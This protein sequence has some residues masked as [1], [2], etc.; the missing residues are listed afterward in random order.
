MN[1]S[2]GYKSTI[3]LLVL[4]VSILGF[5]IINKKV[6]IDR[7]N[8]VVKVNKLKIENKGTKKEKEIIKSGSDKTG[9]EVEKETVSSFSVIKYEIN[10]K[11]KHERN[12]KRDAV[13]NVKLNDEDKKY[14]VLNEVNKENITSKKVPDGL[15]IIVKDVETN[16]DYKLEIEV[17]INNAP[18]GYK[19]SPIVEVKEKTS[20]GTEVRPNTIEVKT[21]SLEGIVKNNKNEP[22]SNV[23][24]E[25]CLMDKNVCINRK[26]TYT[27]A[28]GKYVFSGLGEGEY[29]VIIPDGYILDNDTTL[30]SSGN[31]ELNI[32]YDQKGRFSASIKKYLEK[33]KVGEKE[34]EFDK[35]QTVA[36]STINKDKIE[37]NYLFEIKNVSD[38]DGY[39]K[40]IRESLPDG[41]IISNDELNKDWKKDGQYYINSSLSNE[42]LKVG[43]TKYIRIKIESEDKVSAAEYKNKVEILGESY[44]TVKYV[45]NNEVYKEYEVADGEKI[46]DYKIEREGYTFKGWYTNKSY[47]TKFNFNNLITKDTI[48]YGNLKSNQI[49]KRTVTYM[50]DD[51]TIFDIKE[52]DDGECAEDIP[53]PEKEGYTFNYWKKDGVKYFNDVSC[54]PVTEDIVLYSDFEIN[55]YDIKYYIPGELSSNN[56]HYIFSDSFHLYD[57][58]TSRVDYKTYINDPGS[59]DIKYFNFKGWYKEEELTNK[60][61]Y[62]YEVKKDTNFYGKYEIKKYNVEFYNSRT[63]DEPFLE[64]TFEATS[65]VGE[66]ESTPPENYSI[67]EWQFEDGSKVTF[68]DIAYE[69]FR[70]FDENEVIK[71]YRVLEGIKYK[72]RY[73]DYNNELI[74]ENAEE[75]LTLDA[76]PEKMDDYAAIVG[77]EGHRSGFRFTSFYYKDEP[78]SEYEYD[79]FSDLCESKNNCVIDLVAGYEATPPESIYMVFFDRMGGASVE[80]PK[81]ELFD[82]SKIPEFTGVGGPWISYNLN[83]KYAPIGWYKVLTENGTPISGPDGYETEDEPFS[84]DTEIINETTYVSAKYTPNKY[85]IR[86][87]KTSNEMQGTMEDQVVEYSSDNYSFNPYSTPKEKINIYIH[88]NEYIYPGKEFVGWKSD[89]TGDS[90]ISTSVYSPFNAILFEDDDHKISEGVYL[91]NLYPTFEDKSYW[92]S[93]NKNTGT[94]SMS[95]DSF[96]TSDAATRTLK[97]NAFTKTGYKFKGWS[98]EPGDNKEIVY[99]NKESLVNVMNKMDQLNIDYQT[100]YA[101]FEPINYTVSF[102]KEDDL[103]IGEMQDQAFTYDTPQNLRKNTYTKVGYEFKGWKYGDI[104]YT[105]EQEVTN[106]TTEDNAVITLKTNFEIKKYKVIFMHQDS[107]YE[108]QNNVEYGSHIT[109][110]STNPTIENGNFSGWKLNGEDTIFDFENRVANDDISEVIDGENVIIFVSSARFIDPPVITTEP[111]EWTNDKVKITLSNSNNYDMKL[112]VGEASYV[113]YTEP[114]YT[115]VNTE[116]RGKNYDGNYESPEAIKEITN[117]DKINP[118]VSS[119]ENFPSSNSSVITSS[120]VDEDSGINSARIV[121]TVGSEDVTYCETSTTKSLINDR[122]TGPSNY[123]YECEVSGLTESTTYIG[124]IITTDVAGNESEREIEFSTSDPEEI[125]ARII[126][127]DGVDIENPEDYIDYPSLRTALEGC[128]TVSSTNK[129]TIQM[130]KST[131]ESN[132]VNSDL[133]IVLDLNG[134]TINGVDTVTITNNGKLQIVDHNNTYEEETLESYEPIGKIINVHSTLT[135]DENNNDVEIN[136][137][138]AILNNANAI[139]KIGENEVDDDDEGSIVSEVE[140]H[141]EGSAKGVDVSNSNSTF[142]FYDGIIIGNNASIYGT[143]NGKPLLYD[144]NNTSENGPQEATLKQLAD[145]IARVKRTGVYFT[146][147]DSARDTTNNGAYVSREVEPT[148]NLIDLIQ[149][150][151]NYAATFEKISNKT[152]Y[153]IDQT[154]NGYDIELSDLKIN[155]NNSIKFQKEQVTMHMPVIFEEETTE[156][157]VQLKILPQRRQYNNNLY[158][159]TANEKISINIANERLY[160]YNGYSFNLPESFYDGNIKDIT[161]IKN[162]N[163]YEAYVNGEK[164]EVYSTETYV[165]SGSPS[166]PLI[167]YYN[168]SY[169]Y[170]DFY[171]LKVY[172]KA[173]T[174]EEVITP[175]TDGLMLHYNTLATNPTRVETEEPVL[176]NGYKESPVSYIK[177]DLTGYDQDQKLLVEASK[178]GRGYA[179]AVVREASETYNE[180]YIFNGSINNEEGLF[181]SLGSGDAAKTTYETIIEHGKIYYLYFK[182]STNTNYT[183]D[184]YFAIHSVKLVG[185]SVED[186]DINILDYEV[187]NESNTYGFVYDN[188][189]NVLVNNNQKVRSSVA[190]ATYKIPVTPLSESK[191]LTVNATISSESSDKALLAVNTS[192]TFNTSGYFL[193][194]GGNIPATDYT[195]TLS[196]NTEYYLHIR[197]SK[198]YYTDSYQ[199]SFIINSIKVGDQELLP[200]VLYNE[201]MTNLTYFDQVPKLNT[202]FET[203]DERYKDRDTIELVRDYMMDSTFDVEETRDVVLDLKGHTLTSSNSTDYM[204]NNKGK[205]TITDSSYKKSL[206]SIIESNN[207]I[208]EQFNETYQQ[209]MEEYGEEIDAINEV[210]RSMYENTLSSLFIEDASY[211]YSDY[212]NDYNLRYHY[213]AQESGKTAD[214]WSDSTGHYYYENNERKDLKATLRGDPTWGGDGGLVLDGDGDYIETPKYASSPDSVQSV[215]FKASRLG[216]KQAL[217]TYRERDY[218]YVVYIMPTNKLNLTITIDAVDYS[219]ETAFS[220]SKDTIYSVEVHRESNKYLLYVN[221]HLIDTFEKASSTSTSQVWPNVQ[222]TY[223]GVYSINDNNKSLYFN[224]TIYNIRAFSYYGSVM[225]EEMRNNF[226]KVDAS[227]YNFLPYNAIEP[228][229]GE[230]DSNSSNQ[231]TDLLFDGN[232]N[233][234]YVANENELVVTLSRNSENT[235]RSFKLYGTDETDKYPSSVSLEGSK[236]GTNYVTMINEENVSSKGYGEFNKFTVENLDSYK[237]YRWTFTSSNGISIGEISPESYD[238]KRMIRSASGMEIENIPSNYAIVG[239]TTQPSLSSD[240][241]SFSN[242]L[243]YVEKVNVGDNPI[244]IDGVITTDCN[245]SYETSTYG[246]LRVGFSSTNNNNMNDFVSYKDYPIRGKMTGSHYNVKITE[247]GEYYVKFMLNKNSSSTRVTGNFYGLKIDDT[248]KLNVVSELDS[249]IHGKIMSS[250]YDGIQNSPDSELIIDDAIINI[251]KSGKMAINN[252]GKLSIKNNSIINVLSGTSYGIT[253]N[254]YGEIYDSNG[255][256]NLQVTSDVGINNKSL[257]NTTLSDLKIN[258]SDTSDIGIKQSVKN[259]LTLNNIKTTGLGTSVENLNDSKL[260]LTNIDFSSDIGVSSSGDTVLNSGSIEATISGISITNGTFTMNGGSIIG[261]KNGI[262]ENT[263]GDIVINDG[264]II[265]YVN[266]IFIKSL[267]NQKIDMLGGKIISHDVGIYMYNDIYNYYY[268]SS[269]SISDATIESTNTAIF[270]GNNN[271]IRRISNSNIISNYGYGIYYTPI[272]SKSITPEPGYYYRAKKDLVIENSNIKTAKTSIRLD[273][274]D[275]ISVLGT[276]KI[277]SDESAIEST[278]GLITL[279]SKDGNV[280]NNYPYI[281]S[282]A[283]TF[284]NIGDFNFYDGKIIG[285]IDQ[286]IT[287]VKESEENY[288]ILVN[289]LSNTRE[290]VTLWLPTLNADESNAVAKIGNTKYASLTSAIADLGEESKTIEIIKNYKTIIPVAIGEGKT[291]V[292]DLGN[293][294]IK[295]YSSDDFITNNGNIKIQSD[296]DGLLYSD[297]AKIFENNGTLTTKDL[298][299][300]INNYINNAINNNGNITIDKGC[301][302]VS[303]KD[304]GT[305]I[306]T[307]ADSTITIDTAYVCANTGTIIN[308]NDNSEVTM[309]DGMYIG[310]HGMN[311]AENAKLTINGSDIYGNNPINNNGEVIFNS[312]SVTYRTVIPSKDEGTKTGIINNS[313]FTMNNGTFD[314][315]YFSN[316][317]TTSEFIMNNGQMNNG[318]IYNSNSIIITG[319]QLYNNRIR[320]KDGAILTLGVKG[321]GETSITSPSLIY[322]AYSNDDGLPIDKSTNSTFNFYDGILK[323]RGVGNIVPDEI[324]DGYN[325][326]VSSD[327]T[328]TYKKYLEKLAVAQIGDDKYYSLADAIA[329]DHCASEHCDIEII[330]NIFLPQS[331]DTFV[332]T[333]NQDITINLNQYYIVADNPLLFNNAGTLKIDATNH[334]ANN[335]TIIKC[336]KLMNNTGTAQIEFKNHF[337]YLTIRTYNFVSNTGTLTLKNMYLNYQDDPFID[338]EYYPYV[339]NTGTGVAN[340]EDYIY[341]VRI[342]NS[343]NSKV[344]VESDKE[345]ATG[346]H[347]SISLK[348]NSSAEINGGNNVLQYEGDATTNTLVKEGN[349]K[350]TTSG[351]LNINP[352]ENQNPTVEL[353]LLADATTNVYGGTISSYNNSGELNIYKATITGSQRNTETG[354][355]T[356]G[357]KDGIYEDDEIISTMTDNSPTASE[358]QVYNLGII[359]WYDGVFKSNILPF[360]KLPSDI[361]SGYSIITSSDDTY[362]F[363]TKLSNGPVAKIGTTEFSSLQAAVDSESCQSGHCEIDIIKGFGILK[364]GQPVN[365]SSGR[366]IKLNLNGHPLMSSEKSIISNAGTLEIYDSD[367]AIIRTASSTSINN[368]G[369]LTINMSGIIKIV[370]PLAE[371]DVYINNSGVLNITKLN[372]DAPEYDKNVRYIGI[373]NTGTLTTEKDFV[374]GTINSYSSSGASESSLDNNRVI[375]SSSNSTT[376]I[377]GSTIV[378]QVEMLDNSSLIINGGYIDNTSIATTASATLN[379]GHV[380]RFVS[381]GTSTINQAEGKETE[382]QFAKNEAGGV[383]TINDGTIENIIKLDSGDV[384]STRIVALGNSGTLYLNGGN[385]LSHR[386]ASYTYYTDNCGVSN[387]GTMYISGGYIYSEANRIVYNTGSLNIT[388]G[389]FEINSDYTESAVVDNYADLVIDGATIDTG[390]YAVLMNKKDLVACNTTIKG[391]ASISG[392]ISAIKTKIN[393]VNLTIG[394]SSDPIS[395]TAPTIKGKTSSGIDNDRKATFNFYD[396]RIIGPSPYS[397]IGDVSPLEGYFVKKDP[398]TDD[399]EGYE[400]ATLTDTAPIAKAILV[401]GVNYPTIEEA[402]GATIEG[403]NELELYI[404]ITLEGTYNLKDN[405]TINI[406][407]NGNTITRGDYQF[408]ANDIS[409]VKVYY[410][411]EESNSLL[412]AIRELLNINPVKIKKNIVVYNDDAGHKINS[413]E[414]YTLLY[415]NGGNYEEIDIK[416]ESIP[417]RYSV[418]RTRSDDKMASYNGSVTI[419]DIPEG[420][421]KLLGDAGTVSTFGIDEEG[422]LTGNIRTT[423]LNDTYTSNNVLAS[424]QA[425]VIVNIQTGQ[426]VIKYGLIICLIGSILVLL[427]IIRKKKF[428]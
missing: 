85:I 380:N 60:V 240:Y 302:L 61:T 353:K 175:T 333:E 69:T 367:E 253:N 184:D 404:P 426:K 40:T 387:S 194:E 122:Q 242:G 211:S 123:N 28:D 34:Y 29:K 281:K 232:I 316:E 273:T 214:S 139:L 383:M 317:E 147:L 36:V 400:I 54:T 278:K 48:L 187:V 92:V 385:V 84:F 45:L 33:V 98:L 427:M 192:S 396:G 289:E 401:N 100:I 283:L 314:S 174:S 355:I 37:A 93:Y 76:F 115:T 57:Q 417:G 13:I 356:Y 218:G 399:L 59:V 46:D 217:L 200:V 413:G 373:K 261:Y 137:G 235:I 26:Q 31:N 260:N 119:F 405:S 296:G 87:N 132:T 263:S 307:N 336:Y 391:N 241:L 8:G 424:S 279:G 150:N 368:T 72:V 270:V 382:I 144:V 375:S 354:T 124:R 73:L 44:H 148:D 216:L 108:V 254:T 1:K 223:Y 4:L 291:G 111:T 19:F 288:D 114:V 104:T 191:T 117:I 227:R 177:I 258:M 145:A 386:D 244:V 326:K 328:F 109:P 275:K 169:T 130:V 392:N 360:S 157:T 384:I 421:Y 49:P 189:R 43:E 343:D 70:T 230:F 272:T 133:D 358:S 345:Y 32:V 195:K 79:L 22:A 23:L 425:D 364:T 295:N 165:G 206:A 411:G 149:P 110:P 204:I 228:T 357:I 196:P 193:N 27:D 322:R 39:I 389:N 38:S 105:D 163:E 135:K 324:E 156:E 337:D 128:Y 365:I 35:K 56:D 294:Y 370:K 414:E 172:N 292:I 62:P 231:N 199:D 220:I 298:S 138:T 136:D 75:T 63:D 50:E 409:T 276:S 408:V 120:L 340:I 224:G 160:A 266:G 51:T 246:T 30:V 274:G 402:F 248:P 86:Y 209:K 171:E 103:V 301:S 348:D 180:N 262:E 252:Y 403:Y 282:E 197:Y 11:L 419:L 208:Q 300:Q 24:V 331:A 202:E 81:G 338:P 181:I 377:N 158:I 398:G 78:L 304:N 77:A 239:G 215:I 18:N 303:S 265:S 14:V 151:K 162:N 80:T 410:D 318:S 20:E 329:S 101:Q 5:L 47:S 415:N 225:P 247:P 170:M 186:P 21:T 7:Y 113:D 256:I 176:R 89:V 178:V 88:N 418:S 309:N 352:G 251:N 308:I 99:S 285:P 293:K 327:E 16:I 325:L 94:G 107:E 268:N 90:Y 205:L 390:N 140:P 190:Y 371:D 416:S 67:K 372:L 255:Y 271:D 378:S 321:D 71:I 154:G 91:L 332:I 406:I 121:V 167:G 397:I 83:G 183:P 201:E 226:Y 116:V 95:G 159:G 234:K 335:T 233:N 238:V 339:D 374:V 173:L 259:D 315:I 10:Y 249:S 102:E 236:D 313:T 269:L 323:G 342:I 277:V 41:F 96:T 2:K 428:Q 297:F 361:E 146:N 52:V 393:T 388:G 112:K 203:S 311:V 155:E 212:P 250:A 68:G 344:N 312:G 257:I 363:I 143:V 12:I 152:E 379:Y 182:Y 362:K 118:S 161:V 106:L 287:N 305:L 381:G 395:T 9:T 319:G 166:I 394:D 334:T 306:N 168:S 64:T 65:V 420:E 310:G 129:C 125:I 74:D 299:M 15:E 3:I 376:T 142:Y 237:Y 422:N 219:I 134:K 198:N 423:Y 207:Q 243:Y 188:K 330:N 127:Y 320:N 25:A 350:I 210:N 245:E 349:V 153:L 141:I 17:Q 53:G 229:F 412:A 164:L 179:Y 369:T 58:F 6:N 66:P 346:A 366:D 359:N 341:N 42:I 82:Q 286:T 221:N 185:K 55:K 264:N 284:N 280:D 347:L 290:Q 131:R 97:E 407:T 351:T 267:C 213:D 126:S 222:K